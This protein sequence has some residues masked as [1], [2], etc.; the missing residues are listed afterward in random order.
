MSDSNVRSAGDIIR[1]QHDKL[2]SFVTTIAT[3]LGESDK[4]AY[5]ERWEKIT[6]ER[7]IGLISTKQRQS[8]NNVRLRQRFEL[9]R[10]EQINQLIA[11]YL[12]ELEVWLGE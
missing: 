8:F 10:D 9:P 3:T 5:I 7:L 11:G 4:F 2:Q 6:V 1:E 12:G